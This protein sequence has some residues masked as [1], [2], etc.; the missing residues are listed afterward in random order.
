MTSF[1]SSLP[2]S[3]HQPFQSTELR[4]FTVS[5]S[6]SSPS[7]CLFRWSNLD[8]CPK[9]LFGLFKQD[10]Q[11]SSVN[12]DE[13]SLTYPAIRV[14]K[15]RKT[16]K[17]RMSGSKWRGK[18]TFITA[19][20]DLSF[21]VQRGTIFALLGP[22][23]CGKTTTMRCMG[24][25]TEPD[26]GSIEYFGVDAL[27]NDRIARNMIGFVLQSAGLDKSLTG[28][29][30]LN[31]FAAIAHVD[32]S[33]RGDLIQSLIDLLQLDDFVDRLA[34]VYSGGIIRRLDLAIALLHRPPILILDEPTVG[35][36]VESRRVIW[37][38]L[39]HW[40]DTGGTILLSSHYLEEVDILSDQVA[41][42][43]HG[44]LIAQGTPTELKDGLG[45]DRISVRLEEFTAADQAERA[46]SELR[47]KGLAIDG[48]VNRLK[49]NSIELVVD[50]KD[51]TVGTH[52]VQAL[53]EIGH[54]RLFSFA[55]SKPSLDDVYLAAT[56]QSI[57]DADSLAKS[58]RSEKVMQQE[59]MT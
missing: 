50:P 18:K 11:V 38:V 31:M 48:V 20:D 33:I 54:D 25:L 30:H 51:A 43:D 8:Q 23:S 15:L 46:V 6:R 58:S 28:R 26:S 32:H 52:V 14:E 17:K 3:N 16:F 1:I 7:R 53:A 39:Q 5:R 24:T 47:R 36:D 57:M 49:H 19:V 29:E 9:M 40:R 59:S 35:L 56:G 21:T 2:L 37:E 45:G 13:L 12:I 4:R 41:I 44:V 42:M 34:K 10:E 27:K 55:Q 22:N